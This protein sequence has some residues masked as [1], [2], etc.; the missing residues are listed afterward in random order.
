M[1][2]AGRVGGN[3]HFAISP[4]KSPAPLPFAGRLGANQGS[5][6]QDDRLGDDIEPLD[7]AHQAGLLDK[8]PD[9]SPLRTPK[10]VLDLKGFT[11]PIIW[12][13]TVIECWG[14]SSSRPTIGED[15]IC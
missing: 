5:I 2:F 9:A 4:K 14:Q 6:V 12:R 15:R 7:Q 1:P 11:Q 3:Q 13:S 10:D 8:T